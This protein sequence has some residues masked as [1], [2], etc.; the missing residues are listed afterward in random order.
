MERS[1]I[2][3]PKI[4]QVHSNV[5]VIVVGDLLFVAVRSKQR[6]AVEVPS[7]AGI[8][9]DRLDELGEFEPSSAIDVVTDV[10]GLVCGNDHYSKTNI[11]W[12]SRRCLRLTVAVQLIRCVP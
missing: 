10:A 2:R 1:E 3:F 8:I 7:Q 12:R 6:T 11:L 5:K 4:G 9:E